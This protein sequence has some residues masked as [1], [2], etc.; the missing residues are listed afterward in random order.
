MMPAQFGVFHELAVGQNAGALEHVAQ[1]TDVA[2]PRR[3]RQPTFG[4]RRQADERLAEALR[5]PAHER[6]GEIAECPRAGC[7]A[8]AP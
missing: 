4:F 8:A 5:K 3:F 1:L 2:L 6:R 7:A